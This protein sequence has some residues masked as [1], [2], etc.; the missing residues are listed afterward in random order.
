MKAPA[1]MIFVVDDDPSVRKSLTRLLTS[2]GYAVEAFESAR[3]FLAREP[4]SGP[5]CVVLDVRM[6]GVTGLDLQE[7]LARKVHRIPI[8]FVTGHGDISMSVKA[9][10]AGAVDFLT[11]PFDLESLLEAVERALTKDVADLDEE[12]RTAT[13][14]ER[15]KLLTPR[16]LEVFALVVTGMLNKQIAGELGIGEKTVKVHRA[17]LMEKMRAGSVAELVRL[18]DRAGVVAPKSSSKTTTAE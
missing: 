17:R 2:A 16:E 12:G 15:V 7:A 8:V 10:K 11:K 18:A 3:D 6:P 9:M 5:C 13:V 4:F 1:T 14:L